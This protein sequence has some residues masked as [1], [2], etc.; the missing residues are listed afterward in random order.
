MYMGIWNERIG[1]GF[2]LLN[3]CMKSACYDYSTSCQEE[4]HSWNQ[5]RPAIIYCQWKKQLEV[6]DDV[7]V[8][9]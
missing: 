9:C 5:T 6:F 3:P 1:H 4:G 7:S 8:S 2:F